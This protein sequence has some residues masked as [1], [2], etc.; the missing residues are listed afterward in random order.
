MVA[1]AS[2]SSTFPVDFL[3][4]PGDGDQ[5]QLLQARYATKLRRQVVS[6]HRRQAKM[7]D[8][9]V[10]EYLLRDLERGRTVHRHA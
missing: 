4:V 5:L 10:W 8:C 6:I 7:Q 2:T 3:P 9:S 1:E